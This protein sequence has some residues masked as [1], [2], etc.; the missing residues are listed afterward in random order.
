[1]MG[2]N[3]FVGADGPVPGIAEGDEFEAM[4]AAGLDVEEE[5]QA[6]S[7]PFRF[8][9]FVRPDEAARALRI[10]GDFGVVGPFEVDVDADAGEFAG[11]D[12]QVGNLGEEGG[13]RRVV[14]DE[15]FEDGVEF[16]TGQRLGHGVTRGA[17]GRWVHAPRGRGMVAN[18]AGRGAVNR[19]GGEGVER[20][21]KRGA[22]GRPT[23]RPGFGGGLAH[24]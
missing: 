5:H 6:V 13:A 9:I 17:G 19:E 11:V 3:E 18:A 12:A 4:E 21:E 16:E 8:D 23:G 20:E 15:E 2:P 1:M 22:G 24:D 14:V 7:N 10:D